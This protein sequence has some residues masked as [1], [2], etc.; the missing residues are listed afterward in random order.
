M[1]AGTEGPAAGLDAGFTTAV[2][3]APDAGTGFLVAG[4][5]AA[6]SGVT[7]QVTK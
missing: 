1:P 5:A 3:G 7:D 6:L 2:F 4:W